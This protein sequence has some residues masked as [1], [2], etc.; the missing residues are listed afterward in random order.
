MSEFLK[1]CALAQVDFFAVELLD[2]SLYLL[3]DMGSGT[4]KVKATQTKVNDG[5][6]YHVD[7]QRDGRSGEF[8]WCPEVLYYE[9]TLQSKE[10]GKRSGR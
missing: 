2:G 5:A 8:C 6:W 1:S 10:S 3:L 4:I 9:H 7:I